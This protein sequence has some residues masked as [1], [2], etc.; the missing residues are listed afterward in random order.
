MA[1][2]RQIWS[3]GLSKIKFDAL[4][5]NQI[6]KRNNFC[7]S[8][9]RAIKIQTLVLDIVVRWWWWCTLQFQFTTF[10]IYIKSKVKSWEF[11]KNNGANAINRFQHC[12][13]EKNTLVGCS[14]F[15]LYLCYTSGRPIN[16]PT[17]SAI[18]IIPMLYLLYLCYTYYIYA[19]PR[20]YLHCYTYAIPINRYTYSAVDKTKI[21]AKGNLHCLRVTLSWKECLLLAR[22]PQNFFQL[23]RFLKIVT[24]RNQIRNWKSDWPKPKMIKIS[25]DRGLYVKVDFP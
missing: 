16:R 1:N 4:F 2:F 19:I 25:V 24:T 17:Y 6:S 20:I 21:H 7:N 11:R 22:V 18:P 14:K 5:A 10:L 15:L 8:L 3:H 12:V 23:A 13:A 9:L